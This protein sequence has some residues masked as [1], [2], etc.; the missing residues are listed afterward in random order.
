MEKPD[1]RFEFLEVSIVEENVVC[2]GKARGSIN[3]IF[4]DGM[5]RIACQ[6]TPRHGAFDLQ[7]F[8]A[9]DD[10]YAVGEIMIVAGFEKKRNDDQAI[11]GIACGDALFDFMPD[12]R[13]EDGFE[14]LSRISIGENEL[15]HFCPVELSI[16]DIFRSEGVHDFSD[17]LAVF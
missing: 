9:I 17:R 10:Q 7:I 14:L 13:M 15:A 5:N 6:R 1:C 4:H 2:P 16:F 3:L 11:G 8:T 12:H